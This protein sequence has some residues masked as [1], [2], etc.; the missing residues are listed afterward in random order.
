MSV[1]RFQ[2]NKKRLVKLDKIV[3][4]QNHIASIWKVARCLVFA[5][6]NLSFAKPKK[7]VGYHAMLAYCLSSS[8]LLLM[9]SGGVAAVRGYSRRAFTPT[10]TMPANLLRVGLLNLK[11][12]TASGAMSSM[13]QP[14]STSQNGESTSVLITLANHDFQNFAKIR[15]EPPRMTANR[16]ST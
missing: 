5:Q 12:K 2:G 4:V 14:I 6:S 7:L 13:E 3:A 16:R 11:P 1:K 9:I 10:T 8:G 15:R